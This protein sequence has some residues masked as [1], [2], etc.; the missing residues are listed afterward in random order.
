MIN[1]KSAPVLI[2]WNVM[3]P[4]YHELT[5]FQI[6]SRFEAKNKVTQFFSVLLALCI[7]HNQTS[8]F[9]FTRNHHHIP[10]S[11]T[12]WYGLMKLIKLLSSILL[13]TVWMVGG[14]HRRKSIKLRTFV[15]TMWFEY[16]FE[17]TAGKIKVFGTCFKK[18]AT[19]CSFQNTQLDPWLCPNTMP[20][21][22]IITVNF[23][24]Q[25]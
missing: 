4:W 8:S 20:R 7:F 2:F 5:R 19:C 21:P 6:T 1:Q 15:Y 14:L 17:H 24:Q 23:F 11:H 12:F 22:T 9:A 25:I 13:K 3:A 10:M 16:L 18:M